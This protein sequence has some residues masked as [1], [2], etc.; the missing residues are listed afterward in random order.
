MAFG[1]NPRAIRSDTKFARALNHERDIIDIYSNSWQ[2]VIGNGDVVS[3]PGPM[4]AKALKEGA[5]RVSL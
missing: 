2:A 3:G 1:E 5:E 4:T